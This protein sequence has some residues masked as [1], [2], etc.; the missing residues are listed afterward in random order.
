MCCVKLDEGSSCIGC[1]QDVD[2]KELQVVA[3]HQLP[4]EGDNPRWQAARG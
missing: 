1:V 4:D 2:V 3:V